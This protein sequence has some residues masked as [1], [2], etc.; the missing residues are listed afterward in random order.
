MLR[1]EASD[2]P[3]VQVTV[4]ALGP[5]LAVGQ[6]LLLSVAPIHFAAPSEPE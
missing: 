3:P 6:I 1:A 4:T 5:A 2:F